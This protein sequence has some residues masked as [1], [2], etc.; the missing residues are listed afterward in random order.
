MTDDQRLAELEKRLTAYV[1]GCPDKILQA[2][3]GGY[4]R[5]VIAAIKEL[6]WPSVTVHRSSPLYRSDL[7]IGKQPLPISDILFAFTDVLQP[8]G[9]N[10][11]IIIDRLYEKPRGL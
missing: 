9:P 5:A 4:A 11:Q 6:G 1:E 10:F 3:Y 8:S 7:A 2:I